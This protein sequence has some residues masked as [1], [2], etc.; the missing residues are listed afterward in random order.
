MNV[1]RTCLPAIAATIV[2]A[3]TGI[4]T[5]NAAPGDETPDL[6]DQACGPAAAE[7]E[8]DDREPVLPEGPNSLPSGEAS[9]P[10]L[11]PDPEPG[12][13]P[14]TAADNT[15]NPA[16]D[17]EASDLETDPILAPPEAP[18]DGPVGLDDEAAASRSE[19]FAATRLDGGA[20]KRDI[21]HGTNEFRRQNGRTT[22]MAS[23]R[24]NDVAQAWAQYLADTNQFFHNPQYSTQANAGGVRFQAPGENIGA[25]YR[26][27]KHATEGWINSPGHRANM[28]RT[29]HT[30]IGIG[31]AESPNHSYG[32]IYVQ[33]LAEAENWEAF[34]P[35]GQYGAHVPQFL[36]PDSASVRKRIDRWGGNNRYQTSIRANSEYAPFD[37]PIFIASGADF[38]DALAAAPAAA[39][40]NGRLY[41]VSPHGLEPN[42]P[43]SLTFSRPTE[44]IIVGGEGA[45]PTKVENELRALKVRGE[46]VPVRRIAGDNRYLT[47]VKVAEEFFKPPAGAAPGSLTP[48]QASKSAVVATG[49]NF[50]DALS[51]AA[52]A[53][54]E[55]A[56]IVLVNGTGEAANRDVAR[57]LKAMGKTNV[58][59]LGGDGVVTEQVLNQLRAEGLTVTA[60]INGNDRF[61]TAIAIANKV[62]NRNET[63]GLMVATGLNFADA[64]SGSATAARTGWPIMLSQPTCM[65]S[66]TA[67]WIRNHGHTSRF[68]LGGG[69]AVGNGPA[70]FLQVC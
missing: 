58:T 3:L 25:G 32:R 62:R 56:P 68:A 17:S 29:E 24:L 52:L 23:D 33:I 11:E 5:A 42:G 20:V 70:R 7:G 30:H 51:G 38:A 14:D 44:F 1:S 22:L 47:A 61:E 39:A 35:S 15:G 28:L 26:D 36:E 60:R 49:R 48:A 19:A 27:G 55:N 67:N 9:G 18:L 57:S 31:F 50:P 46:S 6:S 54:Q 45:L 10:C 43:Y 63:S 4:G 8:T 40:A 13:V 37:G 53:G 12:T 16:S 64:L 65:D 34:R 2:L 66:K 59:I 69:A 21:F 41:I